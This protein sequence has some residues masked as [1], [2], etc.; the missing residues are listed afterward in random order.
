MILLLDVE[1]DLITRMILLLGNVGVNIEN[2]GASGDVRRL[3]RFGM[4][5][6]CWLGTIG[7]NFTCGHFNLVVQIF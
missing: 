3:E 2:L 6:V 5:E 1:L 4:G 7:S